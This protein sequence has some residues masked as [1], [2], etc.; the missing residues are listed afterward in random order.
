MDK[1]PLTQAQFLKIVRQAES[2]YLQALRNG[3]PDDPVVMATVLDDRDRPTDFESAMAMA[4]EEEA[5]RVEYRLAVWRREE[6]VQELA[7]RFEE[8]AADQLAARS[9]AD[10]PMTIIIIDGDSC[11]VTTLDLSAGLPRP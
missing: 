1:P 6:A 7:G 10:C 9:D 8:G 3:D 2:L 5:G 4:D 11:R